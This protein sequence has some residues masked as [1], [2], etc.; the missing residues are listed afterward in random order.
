MKWIEHQS[1]LW[2][3]R[4][5][6]SVTVLIVRCTYRCIYIISFRFWIVE[7]Y[8]GHSVGSY[9]Q[10]HPGEWE[11]TFDCR[12]VG[13]IPLYLLCL[14]S[15]YIYIFGC[16]IIYNLD[17]EGDYIDMWLPWREWFICIVVYQ[18][19]LYIYVYSYALLWVTFDAPECDWAC[20]REC[21]CSMC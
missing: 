8:F 1:G 13:E 12:V 11:Y 15:C 10:L 20:D 6:V 5:Y 21:G 14:C 2:C 16:V 18:V 3:I 7:E 19:V 17:C 4:I 9:L